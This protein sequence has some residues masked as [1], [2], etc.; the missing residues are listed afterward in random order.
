MHALKTSSG[1]Y[2]CFRL[3]YCLAFLVEIYV[4]FRKYFFAVERHSGKITSLCS[5]LFW[6][7]SVELFTRTECGKTPGSILKNKLTWEIQEQV[8]V[9]KLVTSISFNL[10]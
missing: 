10:I 3:T 5:D 8:K 1:N 7:Y 4:S 9:V 2:R 6:K